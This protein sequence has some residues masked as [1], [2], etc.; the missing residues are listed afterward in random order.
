MHKEKS[1]QWQRYK[2][3]VLNRIDDFSLLF[4]ALKQQKENADG[5]VTAL[6]PFH[7]DHNPSFAFNRN[8]GRW[9]CFAGCGK[10]G[11]IDFLMLTSGKPFKQT[12]LDLGDR[13]HV[14]RPDDKK[15]RRPPINEGLVK[16]WCANLWANE[17]VIRWLREK[18]GLSDATLKKY[19]IPREHAQASRR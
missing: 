16:Q 5:W 17:E 12:L 18:R 13:F 7:N 2:E 9:A 11:P 4:G 10:G 6:C 19:Q 8:T 14:P 3:E 15:P 1:S